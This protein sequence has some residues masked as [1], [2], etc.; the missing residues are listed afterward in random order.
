MVCLLIFKFFIKRIKKVING[1]LVV[2]ELRSTSPEKVASVCTDTLVV[3]L[4]MMG[5]DISPCL[6]LHQF[7]D[8]LEKEQSKKLRL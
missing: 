8:P 5:T 4:C 7:L 3:I 2:E 1:V 6:S